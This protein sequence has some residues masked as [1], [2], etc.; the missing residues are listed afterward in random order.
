MQMS[1][2]VKERLRN[3]QNINQAESKENQTCW[4]DCILFLTILQSSKKKRTR[5][6]QNTLQSNADIKA[7]NHLKDFHTLHLPPLPAFSALSP[8]EDEVD[9]VLMLV[10]GALFERR[11]TT[12]N[13]ARAGLTKDGLAGEDL[14]WVCLCGYWN[15]MWTFFSFFGG[16]LKETRGRK[17]C[18][19]SFML[20]FPFSLLV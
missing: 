8:S 19:C 20:L 3:S 13:G 7:S 17:T 12:E 18:W 14:L 6:S 9:H 11:L 5:F 15:F 1:C 2:Q 4:T 16:K 10:R